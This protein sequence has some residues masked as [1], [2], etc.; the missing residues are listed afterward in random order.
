MKLKEIFVFYGDELEKKHGHRLLPGHRRAISDIIHCRTPAVGETLSKCQECG[1]YHAHP[2]SC[3]NRNCPTCQNHLTTTWLD[4][5]RAKLLPVRYYLLTFT[6]PAGLRKSTYFNQRKMFNALLKAAKD[7][8][9]E[10]ARNPRHLGAEVGMIAVLHTNS[11]R[12]DFHPHVH[13]ILPGGGI[14]SD[15]SFWIAKS[16]KYLLPCEVLKRR[17]RNNFLAQMRDLKIPYSKSL[18]RI[19]WVV[20]IRAAGSGEPALMYLSKYLYKGVIQEKNILNHDAG[21]VTF[22]YKESD[23][24]MLRTRSLPAADFLFLLLSHT[25]PKRF[26]RVRDYGFLHG[27]ARKTLQKIQIILRSTPTPTPSRKSNPYKFRCPDCGAVEIVI[28]YNFRRL[29]ESTPQIR[30]SPG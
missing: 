2:H 15:H 30:G 6:L 22:Q 3:G 20:N 1:V 10:V 24:D 9:K 4:R 12:L 13:I 28:T 17:F 23:T 27:N 29:F 26:R 11:R 19:D 5:Q 7:T 16:R 18:H 21:I 8:V 14:G 25:L